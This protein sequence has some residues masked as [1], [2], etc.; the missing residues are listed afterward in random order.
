[1]A[2]S[3]FSD[4]FDFFT[5]HRLPVFE[6][7]STDSKRQLGAY[8]ADGN[9]EFRHKKLLEFFKTVDW[10]G[11]EESYDDRPLQKLPSALQRQ[12]QREIEDYRQEKALTRVESAEKREQYRL[13]VFEYFRIKMPANDK[14]LLESLRDYELDLT[15][16]DVNWR[17]Y[18]TLDSFRKIDAFIQ[19]GSAERQDLFA[20][21]KKDVDTYKRNY[22]K[23][24]Q[25]QAAAHADH[26]FTF[27]DWCDLM[28]DEAP[29]QQQ[30]RKKTHASVPAG[31]PVYRAY[32][33]LQLPWGVSLEEVKKQFRRL[34]LTHHPDLAGG[35][36]EKMKTIVGAYQEIQRYLQQSA[37]V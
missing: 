25:A 32:Q 26:G 1:M 24:H 8:L 19:A 27:D 36:E 28:G 17:H 23:I 9:R 5:R 13:R 12:L 22:D 20:R 33:T 29:R 31:N 35:N 4:T 6:F 11:P 37:C 16:R 34:T 15:G 14:I 2:V 21:F 10:L 18:F 3:D 7:L 30:S